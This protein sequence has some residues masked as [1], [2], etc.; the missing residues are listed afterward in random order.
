MKKI[1]CFDFDDVI[2]DSNIVSRIGKYFGKKLKLYEM[3]MEFILDNEN[4]EKFY[5]FAKKFIKM[6]KGL[7]FEYVRRIALKFK[8]NTGSKEALKKLKKNGYKIVIVSAN[9]RRLIKDILKKNGISEYID[10]IYASEFGVVDGKINGKIY[11]TVIKTE[12]VGVV[13]EIEKKYK[14]KAKDVIYVGDGLTDL[15]IMKKIGKGILFCPN[16]V[17]RAEV[18]EDKILSR[19]EKNGSLFLIE[20]KDLREVLNFVD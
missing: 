18:Y 5:H 19:K 16:V 20:K 10:H 4:P 6:G 8:L 3:E 9:D 7:D 15:P 2:V 1:I 13:R 11:G 17:T 14:I 12:K